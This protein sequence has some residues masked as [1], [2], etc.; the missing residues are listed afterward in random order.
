MVYPTIFIAHKLENRVRFK[1]SL[2]LKDP[3]KTAKFLTEYDGIDSFEYNNITRS[4]LIRFNNLKVDLNE[5]MMRL[6][7]SYTKQYNMTPVNI[8]TKKS[9]KSSSLA[10]FSMANIIV[11]ALIK[12]TN[13]FRNKEILNFLSWSAV[14]TTALAILDHGYK[15]VRDKGSFDPEL[16][17]AVYLFNAVKNG[18]LVTG[19]LITW[20]AA[21]GRHTLDLPYDAITVKV[22]EY[23]NIFTGEPQYN[24][25]TFQGAV[26]NDTN[27]DGQLDGRITITRDLISKYINNKPFKIKNNYFMGNNSMLDSKEV[28]ASEFIGD[29]KNII[30]KDNIDNLSI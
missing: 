11:A 18:K 7:I 27:V 6:S 16:V 8:F 3:K 26:I 22:R 9:K 24:L 5:V 30:L 12:S 25:S 10:Y 21:F 14:G 15:E 23:K 4:V 2:P 29:P 28:G 13:P 19:S 17:S 1:L 20:L